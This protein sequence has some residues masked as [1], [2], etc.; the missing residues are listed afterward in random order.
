[1]DFN[2]P[3]FDHNE[4][5][6]DLFCPFHLKLCVME[7][8][9]YYEHFDLLGPLLYQCWRQQPV[10]HHGGDRLPMY[11]KKEMLK[12]SLLSVEEG[13]QLEKIK[14]YAGSLE[15]SNLFKTSSLRVAS[16]SRV[17]PTKAD[18][19]R[20]AVLALPLKKNPLK[21]L[22]GE[23]LTT[24]KRGLTMRPYSD[25]SVFLR[26]TT[27]GLVILAVYVD[28]ILLTGSD[29]VALAETKEYLNCHFVTKDMGKP[30]C[31][32][33]IEV[34]YQR[35]GMLLSQ[36]NYVLDLLEEAGLLGCKLASTPM[37]ANID[38]WRDDTSLL[39]DDGRYRRLIGK[40]IYLIVIRPDIT[41]AVGVLSRF[42]HKPKVVHWTAALKILAY[43]KICP[44]KGLL[45]KKYEHTHIFAF[46]DAGYAGDMGDRKSTSGF[47]T[48]VGGNLV[49]W[50]SKK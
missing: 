14:N 44:G 5:R 10:Y 28:D 2:A 7:L 31:F 16:V 37:E 11:L 15:I 18:S 47:C 1:M 21:N 26:R 24:V 25:H 20:V 12:P 46:S 19:I 13:Q 17:P 50:K 6:I 43:V 22:K 4:M 48:F 8:K 3:T 38:F 30:K 36:R 41:F 33:G 27:T 40:L 49:T 9:D 29:S 45:Y 39:D 42:I 35:H 32:L 23:D 34:T